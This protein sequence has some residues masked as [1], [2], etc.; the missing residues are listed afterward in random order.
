MQMR[1]HEMVLRL[2]LEPFAVH[3]HRT[4]DQ[5]QLADTA[6]VFGRPVTLQ[7]VGDYSL[8]SGSCVVFCDFFYCS[9]RQ[10]ATMNC[11]SCNYTVSQKKVLTLK[12]SVTLS[13]LNRFSKFLHCWKAYE[14]C[15]KPIQH[16]PPHL[17]H[18]A[19]LPW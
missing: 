15:Y 14:I 2:K 9:S 13:I 19:T 4:I 8:I 12:L 7:E 3:L 1:S 17:R 10:A 18:I 5:L 16:Y 11:D 6:N